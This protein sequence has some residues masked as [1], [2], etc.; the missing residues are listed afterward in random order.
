MPEA[1]IACAPRSQSRLPG[2]I[3]LGSLLPGTEEGR[4]TEIHPPVGFHSFRLDCVS[5]VKDLEAEMTTTRD[6]AFTVKEGGERATLV[7]VS[8]GPRYQQED[9][10]AVAQV[11]FS[12]SEQEVKGSASKTVQKALVENEMA[13]ARDKALDLYNAGRKDEAVQQLKEKGAEIST[14]RQALGFSDIAEEAEEGLSSDAD[15]F[16]AP[17]PLAPAEKKSI[18]SESYKVRKQQKDY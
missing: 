6:A 8:T 11:R 16:A 2:S 1:D 15:A 10:M 12:K 18:R 9:S 17:A 7:S 14:R 5:F 4:L 3:F 13:E